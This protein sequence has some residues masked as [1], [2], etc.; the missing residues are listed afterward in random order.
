MRNP[1]WKGGLATVG[2]A[3]MVVG[4]SGKGPSAE[5]YVEV[6]ILNLS[7]Y[8]DDEG[9]MV[10]GVGRPVMRGG[11]SNQLGQ[12]GG[13]WGVGRNT[14]RLWQDCTA[15]SC[16]LGFAWEGMQGYGQGDKIGLLLDCNAGQLVIYKN[17]AR[18][19]VAITGLAGELCW[20]VAMSRKSG[21]CVRITG[22]PPPAALEGGTV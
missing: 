5:H 13:A 15:L 19:G 16:P 12:R 4:D 6:E 3:P 17:G 18:L 11:L 21:G 8:S 9:A 2:G 14:G 22:K 10:I 20:A 1:Q 7:P